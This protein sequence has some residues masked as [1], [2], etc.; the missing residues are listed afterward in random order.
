[1]KAIKVYMTI[2]DFDN[3]IKSK[4]SPLDLEEFNE[5]TFVPLRLEFNTETDMSIEATIVP[6]KN[7][8]VNNQ[9]YRMR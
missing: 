4:L 9:R 1:M 5:C 8:N 2:D 7:G 3:Y 6:V